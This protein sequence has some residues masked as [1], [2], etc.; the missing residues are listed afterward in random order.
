[1][2][3]TTIAFAATIAAAPFAANA[4]TTPIEPS[5][6]GPAGTLSLGACGS[7][8]YTGIVFGDGTAG[9]YTASFESCSVPTDGLAHVTIGEEVSG[10]FQNLVASWENGDSVQVTDAGFNLLPGEV[11]DLFTTFTAATN[12]Q[13]LTFS[14]DASTK[15]AG[16]DY[17]V[18]IAAVPLPAGVLLLGTA[19][20]GLGFAR[21]KA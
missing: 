6:T 10:T 14:W 8:V 9:T 19:L 1:M 21:R 15:F 12:P 5:S 4:V 3:L 16:F 13:E 2:K 7:D 11:F 20:A 17:E 18:S